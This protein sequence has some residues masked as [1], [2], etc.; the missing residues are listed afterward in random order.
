MFD[1][2]KKSLIIFLLIIVF[3]SAFNIIGSN[4]SSIDGIKSYYVRYDVKLSKNKITDDNVSMIPAENDFRANTFS[5]IVIKGQI[6]G[7]PN[8]SDIN[9]IKR[10]KNNSLKAVLLKNGLKSV[11]AKDNETTMSYE[12]AIVT[13][14][15]I[16]QKTYNKQKQIYVYKIQVQFSPL[17]FPDEWKVLSLK[18]KIKTFFNDFF[19]LFK[20]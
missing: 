20:G 10:I 7:L 13:P 18:H 11:K 14:L 17:A 12:G 9:I 3:S 6:S 8:A 4:A 1:N 16:L 5:F 19:Q 15:T 2:I